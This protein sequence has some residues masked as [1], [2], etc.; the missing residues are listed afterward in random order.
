[1]ALGQFILSRKW[2]ASY[3]LLL[4]KKKLKQLWPS[5]ELDI[6]IVLLE[7]NL[8]QVDKSE[9]LP[10]ILMRAIIE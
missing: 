10:Q 4:W 7:K 1:L 2:V 3:A 9:C 6:Q 5:S 8:F